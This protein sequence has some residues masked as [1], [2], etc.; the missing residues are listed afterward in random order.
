M[1]PL[2]PW[3]ETRSCRR[4]Q[5]PVG[6]GS[7]LMAERLTWRFM[8]T[9]ELRIEVISTLQSKWLITPSLLVDSASNGVD[10]TRMT[11]TLRPTR[12]M[13]RFGIQAS[14][15]RSVDQSRMSFSERRFT[16]IS[17]ISPSCDDRSR[18]F[19]QTID[20]CFLQNF[21]QGPSSQFLYSFHGLDVL[22]PH[23]AHVKTSLSQPRDHHLDPFGT[24]R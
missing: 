12:R 22:V 1:P 4:S 18:D 17:C 5:G 24:A 2:N 11:G 15:L 9:G 14:R 7:T 16:K 8:F 10:S 3:T 23:G 20:L 19:M 6:T 21:S 13:P